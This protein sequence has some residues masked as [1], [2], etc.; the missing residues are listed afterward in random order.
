MGEPVTPGEPR[1]RILG[2]VAVMG[3]VELGAP[4]Q[5]AVL[6]ALLLNANRMVSEEQIFTLV[7][8]EETPK[9]VL[10]RVRVYVH[11]LRALLGRDVIDRVRAGYRISVRPGEL[12]LDVFTERITEG[13]T[14][15]KS[16]RAAE[17]AA[18]F[19]AALDLWTG[20]AL[21]GVS[22]P[23]AERETDALEE[24]RL[25]VY[26]ELFDAELA[27]GCHDKVVS[28]VQ[29]IAADHP[30][31]ERLQG[32]LMLALDRSG[33]RS[34]ALAVYLDTHHR[35]VEELGIEPGQ[36]L[37]EIHQ[38]ILD[39][40]EAPVRTRPAELPRDVRG[41]AGREAEL[42]ALSERL[43]TSDGGIGV[44]SGTGGVGKTALAIRW[45]HRVRDQ[46]PDGQ[47]FLNLR[48]YD[49]DHEPLT[50]VAALGQLLQSLGVP[51][52]RVPDTVEQQAGLYRS[53][54]ADRK[55]LVVLDNVR[56]ASQ[57]W[58]LLPPSGVGIVTSRHRLG[59]V[60]AN[61]GA[62][63][64]SLTELT[65]SDA[66]ALL[67]EVLG[68]DRV[69][70]ERDDC[71][72]L[73]RLCGWLPL[74]LRIAAANVVETHGI[75]DVA[76]EL[77]NGD[78]LAEL[79]VDGADSP[80][81]AAFALSYRALRPRD[82]QVFRLLGLVPGPDVTPHAAAAVA[83]ISVAE[84]TK[85]L[86]TLAAAYLIEPQAAQ[87]YR[88]H[89]L[90][91]LFASDRARTDPER[92]Q[93]WDRLMDHYL[94]VSNA[95][96]EKHGQ[97]VL[98]LPGTFPVASAPVGDAMEEL[99]NL[100]A[101]LI[102][103]CAQGPYR[104]AW[105]LADDLRVLYP[106]HGRRLAWLELGP[107]VLEAAK[108]NGEAEVQAMLQHSM[109]E[110]LLRAGQREQAVTVLNNA[111]ALSRSCGWRECEAASLADLSLVLEYTG[112]LAKAIEH[113]QKAAAL[114]AELGSVA[115][116]NRTLNG[117]SRQYHHLG[118][119]ELAED[120]ARNALEISRSHRMHLAM[121]HD[122]RDL[123]SVLLDLGR[124]EESRTYID[125]SITIGHDLGARG[126]GTAYTWLSRWH[127]ET[128]SDEGARAAAQRGVDV[129]EEEG[130]VLIKPA[131]LIALADAEIRLGEY[132]LADRHLSQAEAMINRA[133]LRWHMAY[134]LCARSRLSAA[135]GDFDK[136]IDEATQARDVARQAGYRPPELAALTELAFI[137]SR[138][139]N[140]AQASKTAIAALELCR[141][142]GHA[143]CADRLEPLI[144]A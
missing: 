98:R 143:P 118:K 61:T 129:S 131:A 24:R 11:E 35:L 55:V 107:I 144:E 33:R 100:T 99:P 6:A 84:A 25:N 15:A 76:S 130:D 69:T 93:A 90:V 21:G 106:R 122:M 92:T 105:R 111:V 17:A 138:A 103:M 63:H 133:G 7:W 65:E 128:F 42:T 38:R 102:Q 137:H 43:L 67:T 77:A 68:E 16:G 114:F 46:F 22:E 1:Y 136:A 132:D 73:A 41:F 2:P 141:L 82:R 59:D 39:P 54:L 101:A 142:C 13:R 89:D 110:A 140:R 94:A 8:G 109:G 14:E 60:V 3:D 57:V 85:S 12:D 62:Y 66:L 91:R 29:R 123:G 52:E 119:L 112:R 87:R 80:V 115:G 19:R 9:S 70:E 97:A 47:L 127:W 78:R 116:E 86:R 10:G 51:T 71:V 81:S 139:G 64:A 58:P 44:I 5:R 125:Q 135:H 34:E 95:V 96:V 124:Y 88:F 36:A 72:E 18:K 4:K 121:V 120:C 50:P 53:L 20:P 26:E 49:P 32:Q 126:M 79:A 75:A 23:L 74:A 56:D 45:A 104:Q 134:G 117:L 48:G 40:G 37:R 27:A 28:E 113:N 108:R 30:L 83:G 31:R